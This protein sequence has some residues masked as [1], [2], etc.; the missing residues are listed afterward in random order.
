MFDDVYQVFKCSKQ[1]NILAE[2]LLTLLLAIAGER[3]QGREVVNKENNK[4]WDKSGVYDQTT[5]LF[6]LREGEQVLMQKHFN[7]FRDNRQMQKKA[8]KNYSHK[9]AAEQPTFKPKLGSK[10]EEI[11][12]KRRQKLFKES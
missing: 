9:T 3:E 8:I 1:Q 2:N 5:G 6:Y 4:Q 10:T 7:A 11:S 12:K